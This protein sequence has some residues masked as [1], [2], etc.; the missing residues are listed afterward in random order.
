MDRDRI[1]DAANDVAIANQ[2]SS[3][4]RAAFQRMTVEV[5][6]KLEPAISATVDERVAAGLETERTRMIAI[7]DA[8]EAKGREQTARGLAF[9]SDLSTE[10]AIEIL[11]TM[12]AK[13]NAP[14]RT[15]LSV[16]MAGVD[17]AVSDD[18]GADYAPGGDLEADELASRILNAE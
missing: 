15:P 17:N 1:R 12:P 4:H 5:L 10:Q 6:A 18:D 14:G 7:L 11:K 16:A 13:T 3:Q 9:G 8:P 2:L